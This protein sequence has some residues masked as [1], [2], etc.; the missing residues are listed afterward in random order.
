MTQHGNAKD[1]PP[2]RGAGLIHLGLLVFGL[3]AWMTGLLND[4]AD[5]HKRMEHLV[6]TIHRWLGMGLALFA[7]MRLTL[8][9]IGPKNMRMLKWAP[10]T[11]ARLKLVAKGIAG[12]LTLRR[13]DWT[14]H[15]FLAGAIQAFGLAVFLLMAATGFYLYLFLEPGHEARGFLHDVKELH[16]AGVM[17]IPVFLTLHV[18]AVVAHALYGIHIWRKIFFISDTMTRRQKQPEAA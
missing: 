8:G 16:E 4:D 9:I 13:P 2:G 1:N 5:D 11:R 7:G 3:S 17:L 15:Q 6:Y 18:G 10:Y 12:L 14:T